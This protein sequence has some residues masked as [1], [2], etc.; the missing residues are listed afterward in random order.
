MLIL[1]FGILGLAPMLVLSVESNSI[2]RDFSV[3]AQLAKEKLELYE[4]AAAV[5]SAPFQETETDLRGSFSRVTYITDQSIDSLIP[6][7]VCKIDVIVSWTDGTG[8]I[9]SSQMSTLLGKD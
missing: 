7:N 9:R 2:S 8:M 6:D 4:D 5:P 1:T 3:A